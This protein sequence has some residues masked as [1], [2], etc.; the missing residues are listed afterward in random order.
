[1]S[2]WVKASFSN[3]WEELSMSELCLQSKAQSRLPWAFYKLFSGWT[4]GLSYLVFLLAFAAGERLK[5]SHPVI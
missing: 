4:P 1:M 5:T 2:V 3:L